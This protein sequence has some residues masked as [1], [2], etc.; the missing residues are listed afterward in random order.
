MRIF[1]VKKNGHP[2]VVVIS[3]SI[4]LQMIQKPPVVFTQ[5]NPEEAI[6][7]ADLTSALGLHRSCAISKL[8]LIYARAVLDDVDPCMEAN[9]SAA[10]TIAFTRFYDSLSKMEVHPLRDFCYELRVEDTS[11][12]LFETDQGDV[13]LYFFTPE[14]SLNRREECR[15]D[16]TDFGSDAAAYFI[17]TVFAAHDR[18]VRY[19]DNNLKERYTSCPR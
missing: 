2:D 5:Y 4:R 10:A 1:F 14:K 13:Y 6:S 18:L 15:I 7:Q 19:V 11:L 3:M 9:E 16:L 12:Y 8:W 17:A